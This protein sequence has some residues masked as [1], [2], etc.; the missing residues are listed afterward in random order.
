MV[1]T[2]LGAGGVVGE[3]SITGDIWM[4]GKL[5]GASRLDVTP[6]PIETGNVDGRRLPSCS[7][8]NSDA[9]VRRT[10]NH[11]FFSEGLCA[12]NVVVAI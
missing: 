11:C 1:A 10:A 8:C 3:G 9:D 2:V 5:D 4:G 6:C 12:F 7:S